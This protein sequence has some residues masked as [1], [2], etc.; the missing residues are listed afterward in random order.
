MKIHHI[1]PRFSGVRGGRSFVFCVLCYISLLVLSVLP[2]AACGC[3]L[4]M[5]SNLSYFH[6][7]HSSETRHAD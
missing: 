4:F 3:P 2:V 1:Y 7:K 6:L 5:S